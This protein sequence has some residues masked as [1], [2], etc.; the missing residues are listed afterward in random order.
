MRSKPCLPTGRRQP[1]LHAQLV[2]LSQ[3]GPFLVAQYKMQ[4]VAE[5]RDRQFCATLRR[6]VP[7]APRFPPRCRTPLSRAAPST[8]ATS[9]TSTPGPAIHIANTNGSPVQSH[10]RSPRSQTST[11]SVSLRSSRPQSPDRRS[12]APHPRPSSRSRSRS[13]A[14]P[15]SAERRTFRP[16]EFA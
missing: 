11:N 12:T 6:A 13:A 15:T 7:R 2:K 9:P 5:V 14:V 16:A 8:A 1:M 4:I 10:H 3:P